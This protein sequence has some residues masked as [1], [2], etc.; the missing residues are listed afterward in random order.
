MAKQ[1]VT[2][3]M[4]RLMSQAPGLPRSNPT[5]SV[6]QE[7]PHPSIANMRSSELPSETD[8]VIIGA[9]ITGT[10]AAYTLLHHS[11]ATNLRI[12]LLEARNACSGATGRNGGHLIS[13]SAPDYLRLSEMLGTEAA[14]D[15]VRFSEANI[16]RLKEVVASLDGP[17]QDSIELRTVNS[18]TGFED[19]IA[20]EH[21]AKAVETL[22]SNHSGHLKHEVITD[23]T[24]LTNELK[25]RDVVGAIGQ[26][27]AAALWP[28]RLITGVLKKLVDEHGHRFSLETNTP[29]TSITETAGNYSVV[30]PR[31]TIK[32]SKIIHCTNGYLGHLLPNLVGKVYPVKATMSTQKL[33]P[34]FPMIGDQISWTYVGKGSLDT[35]RDC[36]DAAYYYAQQNT[37][38]GEMFIGG[39]VTT[40]QESFTSDDSDVGKT[41]REN[42]TT[43]VL[44]RIFTGTGGDPE[45]KVW[46]GIMGWTADRFPFVGHL[47]PTMSGRTGV[48][49]WLAG[50][51]NGHGMDKT[52]LCGDAVAR[53]SLVEQVPAGFPNSYILTD[54]RF[55]SLGAA[56]AAEAFVAR[57]S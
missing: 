8:I 27:G 5:T 17:T 46:S 34:S 39:E 36:I 11:E 6:W 55:Q 47:L 50:G 33:G 31:G 20:F 25:F 18:V 30:T 16:Q 49:E 32:A 26:R 38:T 1:D 3:R 13:D 42:L 9:G 37:K 2:E 41:P 14:L 54:K 53:M 10:S 4:T 45:C 35:E 12:T 52:W 22:M 21:V 29:V 19:P 51:F 23:Q 7:P 44:P 28:Y 57:V 48:G 15:I 56:M 24:L 40:L 43:A